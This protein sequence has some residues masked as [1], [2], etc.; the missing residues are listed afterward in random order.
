MIAA[1]GGA[2]WLLASQRLFVSPLA[3]TLACSC[4]LGVRDAR[5]VHVERSR[6]DAREP[7][8]DAAQRLMDAGAAVAD[9]GPRRRDRPSFAAHAAVRA[10]AGGALSSHPRFRDYLTA[11]RIELLSQLAPLHDIGKVGVPDRVLNKPGRRRPDELAEMRRHPELGREVILRAE[12]RVG[13]RD[14]ATLQMAKDIVY[15]HH[16]QWDGT[17]I[18]RGCDGTDIP[19]VGRIM[20]VVDVYDAVHARIALPAVAPAPGDRSSS[21]SRDGRRTSIRTWSMPFSP[22]RRRSKRWLKSSEPRRASSTAR[23]VGTSV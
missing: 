1:S 12:S 13:V 4:T 17:A 19:V 8:E 16:E 15:T 23:T 7:R 3:P 11:E 18:R 6:A 21:S 20:A 5:A 22:C 9:R 2:R 10:A 14:E